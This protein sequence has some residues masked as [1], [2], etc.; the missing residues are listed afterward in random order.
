MFFILRS[1]FRGRPRAGVD[2]L[3][4][5]ALYT[6]S[7]IFLLSR[8]HKQYAD[9]GIVSPDAEF[10]I[11]SIPEETRHLANYPAGPQPDHCTNS[12]LHGPQE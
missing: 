9:G 11:L 8:S 5:N 3:G 2:L 12:T 10:V 4:P 1:G 6:Y 7:W